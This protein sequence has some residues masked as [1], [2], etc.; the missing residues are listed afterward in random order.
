MN[1]RTFLTATAASLAAQQARRPNV[2]FILADQWRFS[3]FTHTHDPNARTPNFDRLA[4]ESVYFAR[5]Y[6]ANP[7]CTPN[8]SCILTGRYSHQHGM[9]HNDIML[10]PSERPMPQVFADAGYATEYIGKWHMDGQPKPGFVPPGWRR[11]GIQ[12]FEGFNRGHF[13]P[14][15]AQYFTSD[16]KLIHPD[17]F[18]AT[19]EADLAMAFM[20]RNRTNPF[21]CYLSW[22]PPHPP[23]NPPPKWKIYDKEKIVWRDN[24]PQATREDPWFKNA[25]AGYYGLCS[26]LDFELS[27]ILKFLDDE[28]LAENTLLVFTSDH[29]DMLG[30]HAGREKN[31]PEEESLHVP[32][33]MRL[34]GRIRAGSRTETLFSS[35]DLMPTILSICGLKTPSTVT[36]QDLSGVALGTGNPKVEFVYAEGLMRPKEDGA[37]GAGAAV[38]ED[39]AS[40]GAQG[41]SMGMEW[42][43]VVT[44]QHKLVVRFDAANSNGIVAALFDRAKDPYELKNLAEE[45]SA[46][47]LRNDLWAKLKK[48]GA[49]TGDRFPHVTPAAKALY[50]DEEAAKS[51]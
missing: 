41:V 39:G 37:N 31:K 11:R 10:P 32:L 33:Y 28:G 14:T 21:F 18:S 6:A 30:S 48:R 29:G 27:R 9:I 23:Y 7:V 13:Y 24:V 35:I 3:A 51:L 4:Q 20:K 44:D 50:T 40:L 12:T 19:S 43:T 46:T 49:D 26:A 8:R 25:A 16:G 15:G 17:V 22:G 47:A 45:R 38:G 1:R 36:G 42:R 2:L 34:P 5:T